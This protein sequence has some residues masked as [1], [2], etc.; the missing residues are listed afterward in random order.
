MSKDSFRVKQQLTRRDAIKLL[1][2]G[3]TATLATGFAL[4]DVVPNVAD[5]GGKTEVVIVGAGF[6][7]LAAARS[8]VTQGK[9]V[10]VLEARDRVGGRVKGGK[11]AGHPVDV[12]GMWAGPGQTRVLQL[13]KEYG[14]HLV[15]QFEDG[16]D[17]SEI[18]GVRTTA[19][20][21]DTGLNAQAQAEYDRVVQELNVLT[22]Q[23]PLDAPWTAPRAEALD[24]MTVQD[25]LDS[26]VQ[27]KDT[28]S[29][30]QAMVRSNY[31][32]DPFQLSFLY[33]LFYLRSA[34]NFE[35][36]I[37]YKNAAQAFLVRETMYEL[38]TRMAHEL[39]NNIV[40]EA[41]VRAISQTSNNVTVNSDKG[42]WQCDYA[43]VAVPLPLS[44]RIFYEPA[45]PPERDLLA[46][47][48][49]MGSVIKYWVAYAK[50]FWRDRG[51]NGMIWSDEPPSASIADA[52]PSD[53]GPGFL[54][55]FFEAQHALKW[56]GRPME[57]RKKFIV[58]RMVQWLG[59][60]AAHPIDYEDQDWPAETWSRGCYGPVMGPGVFTSVG[61]VI[62]QPHGRIHWAGSET[63]TRWA[64]YIDGAI[65]S[66]ERAAAEVC[67][68]CKV[69]SS[70]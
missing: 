46:Q 4:G 34:D 9:K 45:L 26:A 21:E 30:I 59:P 5:A 65:R 10:V 19:N 53:R 17:I 18:N 43:I 6:A 44:V 56:T 36:V 20:G 16:K 50:P 3:T 42:V 15:P 33:F 22:A 48:T 25:W 47:R 63:S 57:E 32:A 14:L 60:E 8:L 11:L 67:S 27:N 66:G 61:K 58:D 55:G 37:G 13:I 39:S 29:F 64:G 54:V 31:A 41:P 2:V 49:P 52:S 70:I 28:R 24:H 68:L 51:L 40:L 23:L 1:G 35:T 62:R 38:A 12:G 7:G 69:S